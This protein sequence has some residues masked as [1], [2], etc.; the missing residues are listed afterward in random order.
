MLYVFLAVLGVVLVAVGIYLPRTGK[1]IIA[2]FQK[3]A[4]S[5]TH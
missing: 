2:E 4:A 1:D 3:E 5:A